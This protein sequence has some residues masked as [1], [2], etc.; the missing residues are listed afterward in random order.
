MDVFRLSAIELN[1]L[2]QCTYRSHYYFDNY[3][4]IK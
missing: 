2:C 4:K 1:L 3:A